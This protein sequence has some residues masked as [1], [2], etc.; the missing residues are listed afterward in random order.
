MTSNTIPIYRHGRKFYVSAQEY[1]RIRSEERRQRRTAVQKT[2]QIPIRSPSSTL[3]TPIQRSQ[4]NP[5]DH[6]YGVLKTPHLPINSLINTNIRREPTRLSR[7]TLTYYNDYDDL[8]VLTSA[9]SKK[10]TPPTTRSNSSDRIIN[11]QRTTLLSDT[12]NEV[13]R[14]FSAEISQLFSSPQQSK[15][16]QPSQIS[17]RRPVPTTVSDYGVSPVTSFSMTPNDQSHIQTNPSK[18]T[19][20]LSRM[21]QSSLN[22]PSKSSPSAFSGTGSLFESGIQGS[23]HTY[24]VFGSTNRRTGGTNSSSLLT[25]STSDS[26]KNE[27]YHQDIASGSFSDDNSSSLFGLIQRRN[28]DTNR[29]RRIEYVDENDDDHNQQRDLWTRSTIRSQS[30][31]GLTE[32]KHVRFADME[33]LTLET[34][35]DRNQLKSPINNRLL[36][37]RQHVKI[38]SDPRGQSRLFHNGMYQT[39]T[40]VGGSKLATDV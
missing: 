15:P 8:S 35:P 14:P 17:L 26:N 22:P 4:S 36:T 19:N 12:E 11:N 6:K 28:T 13:K 16:K 32:K 34:I 10:K 29:S 23:D 5:N 2:N 20:Y 25:R 18:L 7:P 33:G 38:S 30:S 21:K 39:T 3:Y 9:V 27:Y 37:R 24:T 40:K 1:E 31:D